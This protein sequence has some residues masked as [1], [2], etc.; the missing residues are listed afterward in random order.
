MPGQEGHYKKFSELYGTETNESHCPSLQKKSNIRKTLPF[1]CSLRHVKNVD[2]M[3]E[4]KH[5]GLR[6]PLYSQKKLSRKEREELEEALADFRFTCGA[7]L[8]ELQLAGKLAEVYVKDISCEDPIERLYYTAKCPPICVH[9]ACP[10]PEGNAAAEH[11][12]VTLN[13]VRGQKWSG[14]TI[15]VSKNGP[16]RTDYVVIIDPTWTI[17]FHLLFLERL[18]SKLFVQERSRRQEANPGITR[19]RRSER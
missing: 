2:M 4:C 16:S 5:C 12:P 8:Q 19:P 11:Y 14:G 13:L 7:P 6:R 3:L 1:P 15:F 17:L 18:C 10:M 9:C